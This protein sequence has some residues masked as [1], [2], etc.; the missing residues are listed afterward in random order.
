M[1]KFGYLYQKVSY[2]RMSHDS[3][4]FLDE[5]QRKND[6]QS[7]QPKA[8]DETQQSQLSFSTIGYYDWSKSHFTD[9]II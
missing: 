5:V 9:E 6:M 8:S 1:K 2:Q 4:P 7:Y 3:Q